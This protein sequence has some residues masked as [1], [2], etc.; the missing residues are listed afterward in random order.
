LQKIVQYL[1][2]AG[3]GIFTR[4]DLSCNKLAV[5]T[6]PSDVE[7][8]IWSITQDYGAAALAWLVARDQSLITLNVASNSIGT[9][10]H[11]TIYSSQVHQ[12]E[13]RG[14]GRR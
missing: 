1:A 8:D 9:H 5:T 4:L 7:Y 13:D 10:R 6:P 12:S 14:C 2:G 3:H 11:N